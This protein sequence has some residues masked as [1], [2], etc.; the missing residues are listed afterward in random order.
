MTYTLTPLRADACD[1]V[2]LALA[3]L[4]RRFF[5]SLLLELANAL[6]GQ[7]PFGACRSAAVVEGVGGMKEGGAGKD[8]RSCSWSYSGSSP[9]SVSLSLHARLVDAPLEDVEDR[10]M[11]AAMAA[12]GSMVVAPENE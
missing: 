3:V 10:G 4:S 2:L 5:L 9:S 7:E 1:A 6:G 12:S 8:V 11:D